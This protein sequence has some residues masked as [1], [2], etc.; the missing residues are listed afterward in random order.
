[1]AKARGNALRA[2]EI[3][4]SLA[5]AH[6]SLGLVKIFN[7]WDWAGA[8][9]AFLRAIELDPSYA[10]GHQAYALLLAFTGRLDQALV[11]M[12]RAHELDP[13]SPLVTVSLAEVHGWRGEQEQALLFWEQALELDAA[14]PR[15]HQSL[16]GGFCRRGLAEQAIA[17]LESATQG[18]PD[19]PLLIADLA[20]CNAVLG[21]TLRARE[22]FDRLHEMTE[23]TYV[24]PMSLAMVHV[25]LGEMDAAFAELDRAYEQ[26]AFFLVFVGVDT[27][28]EPLR[29]DPRFAELLERVGLPVG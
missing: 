11:E 13:L 18:A 1:M 22:L 10:W 27:P 5:E 16:V 19:D 23:L 3:D 4:D 25:G 28:F 6:N 12:Q 8:E 20:Y 2:L 15:L 26:R 9:Q 21:Q 24:S 7:E 14:Y 17:S 29:D